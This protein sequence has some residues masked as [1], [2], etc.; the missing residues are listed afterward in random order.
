VNLTAYLKANGAAFEVLEKA[1]THHASDASRAS[2]IPIEE[3]AKTIVFAGDRGQLIVAVLQ[4]N[5]MVSRHKLETCSG[6]RK[7][8]VAADEVAEKASGFPTGG[9]PPVGHRRP[10]P[11]YLDE[12]VSQLDYVWCGGGARTRLVRLSVADILRL[13]KAQICDI[14]IPQP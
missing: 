10:L 6:L 3:I 5:H 9:I 7:I 4:G 12:R 2:G 11:V 1:T 8:D 14:A 13:S